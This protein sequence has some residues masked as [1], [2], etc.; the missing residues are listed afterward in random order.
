VRAAIG[1]GPRR[2]HGATAVLT[3]PI[4]LIPP[5]R[6]PRDDAVAVFLAANRGLP[7]PAARGS[8]CTNASLL[9][10]LRDALARLTPDPSGTAPS[11]ERRTDNEAAHDEYFHVR[12]VA[13]DAAAIFVRG[14]LT[15]RAILLD[16]DTDGPSAATRDQA[17]I[18]D[19]A[20]ADLLASLAGA[21]PDDLPSAGTW[22]R[23]P[24]R[25]HDG[26]RR[27]IRGH[28][29]FAVL[30]QGL[31]FALRAMARAIRAGDTTAACRWADTSASLMRGSAA[32]FVFAGDFDATVYTEVIRPSMAPPIARVAL[33][34]VMSADHRCLM[35][36][37]RD[38]R[39]ALKSLGE[40][41]AAR[42]ADL[43]AN[44]G[45]VY[46]R[47]I[48]VC[49]TFVGARPSLLTEGR[50]ETSGPDLLRQF[51]ALRLKPLAHRQRAQRLDDPPAYA[52]RPDPERAQRARPAGADRD[53]NVDGTP[54]DTSI[55]SKTPT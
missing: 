3:E 51:K 36:T 26:H 19:R 47:H 24:D 34:G 41:D 25:P 17:P 43:H 10:R 13:G 54:P 18:V 29:V 49:E 12:R 21:T 52:S 23:V 45:T 6:I 46:D 30:T 55:S 32:A 50:A 7:G 42:L 39:P 11:A 27:W 38:M 5:G 40:I 15:A 31:I 20:F 16:E 48:H 37:L 35:D 1:A 28:Q 2:P 9:P 14:T 4:D 44:L 33:S 22:T 8:A 53:A